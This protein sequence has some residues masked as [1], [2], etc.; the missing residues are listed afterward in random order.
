MSTIT[1]A[2][3]KGRILKETLPLLEQSDIKLQGDVFASR[4]LIFATNQPDIRCII[5]RGSDVPTYVQMGTADIGVAGKDNLLE[6]QLSGY[7]EQLDL[8]IS[9][10]RLSTAALKGYQ[11]HSGSR[12]K[13][14]TKFINVARQFYADK[15]IQAELIKLYGAIELTP[16]MNLADE[17]VDIV[18]SGKTLKANGL[19]VLE[20][21]VSVSSRL[22][23][24][25]ASMK[26]K[27]QRVSNIIEQIE[28]TLNQQS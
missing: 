5:L 22:I 2:L 4:K 16:I 12:I 25:H 15:G 9:R 20:D 18:D 27:Y 23:V 19:E 17:I 24:N 8:G 14:A 3:T 10:C 11:R 6:Q 13:V 7:Y 1:I 28:T 26:L 21:I